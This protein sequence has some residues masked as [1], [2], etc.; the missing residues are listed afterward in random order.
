M[1]ENGCRSPQ[2]HNN[3][4]R[5]PSHITQENSKA[6]A[7]RNIKRQ[8]RLKVKKNFKTWSHERLVFPKILKHYKKNNF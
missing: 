5:L 4:A 8:E 1:L 6:I 7:S 2:M 3:Y